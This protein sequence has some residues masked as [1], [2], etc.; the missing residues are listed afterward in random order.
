[1]IEGPTAEE[2][3]A[4]A[5]HAGAGE[6]SNPYAMHQG[7]PYRVKGIAWRKGYRAAQ[8]LAEIAEDD[9]NGDLFRGK[10]Q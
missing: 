6:N 2:Q 7:S 1:M 5:F 9:A 10:A 3:G 4:G 8:R